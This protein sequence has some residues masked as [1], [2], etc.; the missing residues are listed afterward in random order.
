MATLTRPA[1]I[2]TLAGATPED[3]PTELRVVIHHQDQLRA[4]LELT[5]KGMDLKAHLHLST[6]FCWAAL[7]RTGD[8]GGNFDTFANHDLLGLQ[9]GGNDPVG[10][11]RTAAA[12]DSPSP[13]P[14]PTPAPQ[15]TTG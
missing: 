4:E 14:S 1:Y 5:R 9:D 13:S 8:Y 2:V 6:A 3:E 12:T 7:K 11:T 15:L 10:P